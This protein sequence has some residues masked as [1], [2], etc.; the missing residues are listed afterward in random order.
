MGKTKLPGAVAVRLNN[1]S[2]TPSER[3]VLAGVYATEY[4]DKREHLDAGNWLEGQRRH[5]SAVIL[6]LEEIACG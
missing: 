5:F 1:P 3:K 6:E 4:R 2:L